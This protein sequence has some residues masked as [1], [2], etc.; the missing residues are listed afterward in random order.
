[1]WYE[2]LKRREHSID[3]GIKEDNIRT[4]LREVGSDGVD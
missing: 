1:L 4:D 2:N 3:I